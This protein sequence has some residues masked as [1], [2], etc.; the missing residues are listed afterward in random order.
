MSKFPTQNPARELYELLNY[1]N[2]LEKDAPE[3]LQIDAR[4]FRRWKS[5]QSHPPHA[6]V[7]LL[8]AHVS[9]KLM[10]GSTDWLGFAFADGRL[11]CPDGAS[12][13]PADIMAL[14]FAR[15][16]LI[17]LRRIHINYDLVIKDKTIPVS[18]DA[19]KAL[20]KIVRPK[21]PR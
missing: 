13:T 4:T 12:Y 17:E 6:A 7:A 2:L 16:A 19:K 15:Q 1:G 14:F 8:K 11:Y 18:L 21:K 9:G 10:P 20:E 3:L 5:G